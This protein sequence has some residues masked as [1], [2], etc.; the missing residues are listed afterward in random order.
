MEGVNRLAKKR[1][2]KGNGSL[3]RRTSDGLWVYSITTVSQNK[4]SKIKR[5]KKQFYGRTPKMAYRKYRIWAEKRHYSALEEDDI[6]WLNKLVAMID[7]CHEG[8]L[9]W[10]AE[11]SSHLADRLRTI[12]NSPTKRGFPSQ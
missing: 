9:A 3:Y 12:A 1:Q 5:E 10:R 2:K 8:K 4:E 7:A 11:A 6:Q